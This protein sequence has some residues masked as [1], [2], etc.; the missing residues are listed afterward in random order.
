MN[1]LSAGSAWIG[2][3]LGAISVGTLATF[4]QSQALG[5]LV[6]VLLPFALFYAL[7]KKAVDALTLTWI[8][9]LLFGSSGSWVQFGP[10]N[11]R[12]I[13]LLVTLAAYFVFIN[14][15]TFRNRSVTAR[16]LTVVFY[17]AVLPT[18]LLLYAVGVRSADFGNALGDV[19][20]FGI[21]L[22]Y[23]PVRLLI[24][25]NSTVFFDYLR[26]ALFALGLSF[27]VMSLLPQQLKY[28]VTLNVFFL[29]E[30][31][32]RFNDLR[33]TYKPILYCFIGIFWA[34]LTMIKSPS[35][36]R[37]VFWLSFLTVSSLPFLLNTLRGPIVFMSIVVLFMIVKLS[38]TKNFFVFLRTTLVTLTFIVFGY[39]ITLETMFIA[40]WQDFSQG[41]SAQDIL[42]VER[43]EQITVMLQAWREEPFM[44]QGVGV[45][46]QGYTRTDE[47]GGLSFEMQYF[48]VLYRTGIIGTVLI[49]IPILW[50]L[51]KLWTFNF[52]RL[53]SHLLVLR[54]AILMAL[55]V[56]LLSATFNPYLASSNTPLLFV[57]YVA[58]DKADALYKAK[59]QRNS[60]P[61]SFSPS[62]S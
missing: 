14:H 25:R 34:L 33:I 9:E 45:P 50:A 59:V 37:Q 53:D 8:N 18:L 61:F 31:P 10:L 23:F 11:G 7:T 13:L 17:G 20:R 16:T 43:T 36:K 62:R 19:F 44:G 2:F 38:I 41:T 56:L 54:A 47:E 39:V 57:L 6:F 32:D 35:W 26:G 4:P 58:L 21:V 3:L 12:G 1:R 42:S 40:R 55:V 46:I 28:T 51:W 52:N 29:G 22:G 27:T 49:L 48:M 5:F 15:R 60:P 30:L 24:S